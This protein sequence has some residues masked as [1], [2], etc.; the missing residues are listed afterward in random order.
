MRSEERT[1]RQREIEAL[2]GFVY[3]GPSSAWTGMR[4]RSLQRR[5]PNQYDWMM[6]KKKRR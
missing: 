1:R 6:A 5:F 3:T 2:R 4:Y